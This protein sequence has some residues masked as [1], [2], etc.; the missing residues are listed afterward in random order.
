MTTSHIASAPGMWAEAHAD[1]AEAWRI[2][3]RLFPLLEKIARN[4]A[5][6]ELLTEAMLAL[7]D[8][9]LPGP[10]TAACDTLRGAR[11]R[12]AALKRAEADRHAQADPAANGAHAQPDGVLA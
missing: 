1:A 6:D 7:D 9:V 11:E 12:L 5:L 8:G 2:S 3:A 4:P 10:F